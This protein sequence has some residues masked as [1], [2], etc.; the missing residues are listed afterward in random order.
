MKFEKL[1][2]FADWATRN[3]WKITQA[4]GG[5]NLPTEITERYDIPLEY[6]AFLRQFSL[7]TNAAENVWFLC[8]EEFLPKSEDKF[9]WN[10]FELISLAAAD[11]GGETAIVDYWDRHF[12]IIMSVKNGYEYYAIHLE[13]GK[14]IHGCEPEFEEN[15]V[16]AENFLEFLEHYFDVGE[17]L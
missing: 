14:V 17:I 9:R 15:T 3:G 1:A 11:E 7:F 8:V 16:I 12:P 2:K 5:K 13:S 10:E 4:D 6:R